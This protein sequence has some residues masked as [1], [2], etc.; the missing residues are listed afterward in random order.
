M[1]PD[2]E[3]FLREVISH[4]RIAG[5][6]GVCQRGG[7]WGRGKG[8]KF[9]EKWNRKCFEKNADCNVVFKCINCEDKNR[10]IS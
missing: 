6:V 5:H 8:R 7:V 2:L 10:V 3:G 4:L 1:D 9:S